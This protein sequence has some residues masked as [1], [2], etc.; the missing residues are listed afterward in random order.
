[1]KPSTALTAR[2]PP[3]G[4]PPADFSLL[5]QEMAI[6]ADTKRKAGFFMEAVVYGVCR[7]K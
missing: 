6:R 7:F 4:G 3:V 5:L 2:L 1:M